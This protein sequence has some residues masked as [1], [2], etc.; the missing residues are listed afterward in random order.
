M[1]ATGAAHPAGRHRRA[2][3]ERRP[4]RRARWPASWGGSS[5]RRGHRARRRSGV[6]RACRCCSGWRLP[7]ASCS[8]SASRSRWFPRACCPPSRCRWRRARSGWPAATR[9]SATWRR[10]RPSASTT[11]ICTDK[12]GTLTRNEMT[13]VQVWTPDGRA[14]PGRARHRAARDHALGRARARPDDWSARTADWKAV[15][16]PDGGRPGRA[17]AARRIDAERRDRSPGASR[18]TRAAAA[19]R[20]SPTVLLHRQGR[21][22]RGPARCAR[23]YR[24]RRRRWRTWPRTGCACWPSP[25][26]TAPRG[27]SPTRRERGPDAARPGRPRG[28]ARAR[29]RGGDRR[30]PPGRDQARHDHRRPSRDRHGRSPRGRPA[31]AGREL[32]LT[33]RAARER[34]RPRRAARPRR[35]RG[36]PGDAGGQAAHRPGAARPRAT[37]WR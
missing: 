22:G 13:V 29:R 12:T 2:D 28:P 15:G 36:R 18:S 27:R 9:W 6:L 4:G 37:S 33:A 17:G 8:P 5:G 30:V 21:A 7:T 10:W 16:R 14:R 35:R 34:R 19:P 11:F 26:A 23:P 3:P 25:G 31:R 1:T 20:R 32:V 24:G